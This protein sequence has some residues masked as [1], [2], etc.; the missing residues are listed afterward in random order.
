MRETIQD[1]INAWFVETRHPETGVYPDLPAAD[2][3]GCA[4]ANRADRFCRPAW[5]L[6]KLRPPMRQDTHAPAQLAPKSHA[7]LSHRVTSLIYASLTCAV[8]AG[9]R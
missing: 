3:G 9:P 6:A 7:S 8:S 4:A 5:H 2:A 1:K